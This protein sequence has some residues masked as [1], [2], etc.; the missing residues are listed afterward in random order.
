MSELI[1]CFWPFTVNVCVFQGNYGTSMADEL[2]LIYYDPGSE[3]VNRY[4]KSS[5]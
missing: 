5:L 4:Q 1:R 2:K 3:R